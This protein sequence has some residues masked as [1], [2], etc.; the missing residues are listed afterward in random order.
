MEFQP[1]RATKLYMEVAKQIAAMINSGNLKKGDKLPSERILT[2]QFKISRPPIRE[3]ISALELLGIL[4]SRPGSGTFVRTTAPDIEALGQVLAVFGAQESPFEILEARRVLE[5][6]GA[7]LAAKRGSPEQLVRV[8]Q[9][10]ESMESE[11]LTSGNFA[12]EYDRHFHL[13]IAHMARNDVL[14]ALTHLVLDM[15]KQQLWLTMR[16]RTHEIPGLASKYHEQHV[17][18]CQ[19]VAQ[20]DAVVARSLMEKHLAEVQ[21]DIFGHEVVLHFED[22]GSQV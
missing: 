16:N 12:M 2:G 10:L 3:A 7:Y 21:D 8:R 15:T 17:A 13:A 1:V 14:Y 18:I 9:A 6:M 19:I 20:G 22:T 5:P 4:E 11:L